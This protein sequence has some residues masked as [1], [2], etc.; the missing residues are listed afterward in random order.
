M[1]RKTD[2]FFST[3]Q[4]G[5]S[6]KKG[7]YLVDSKNTPS[8]QSL[9][10]LLWAFT[11]MRLTAHAGEL[12]DLIVEVTPFLM[13]GFDPGRGTHTQ[14]RES[15]AFVPQTISNQLWAFA[16]LKKHP[17]DLHL[18]LCGRLIAENV[19]NFKP[20]ELTNIVW[21]FCVLNHFPGD[22]ILVSFEVEIARRA[23]K[24]EFNAQNLSTLIL[25]LSSFPH[26]DPASRASL[27][28]VMKALDTDKVLA[29]V[30]RFNFQDTANALFGAAQMVSI[31][32]SPHS[33]DCFPYETDT[34][35]FTIRAGSLLF[36][37]KKPGTTCAVFQTPPSKWKPRS[38]SPGG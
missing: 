32:Q 1:A 21:A 33:A 28:L 3:S 14:E 37:S 30:E 26:D 31:S 29:S 23:V 25:A 17:G 11:T 4:R 12:A 38:N 9:S 20:Q 2:T 5:L 10:N 24:G 15:G 35:S 34:F 18:D 8:A 36:F 6:Q 19:L 7:D 13:R 22:E 16:V 27:S